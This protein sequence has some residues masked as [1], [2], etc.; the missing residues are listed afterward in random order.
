MSKEK[1]LAT[2]EITVTKRTE[3]ILR[4]QGE[5]L[6]LSVGEVVDRMATT[7]ICNDPDYTSLLLC[8]MFQIMTREQTYKQKQESMIKIMNVFYISMWKNG[9]DPHALWSK[10]SSQKPWKR[11]IFKGK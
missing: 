7:F 5:E 3:D 8:D 11:E 1:L 4:K 9:M 10:I 6:G 2:M